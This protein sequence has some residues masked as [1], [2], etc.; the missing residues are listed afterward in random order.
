MRRIAPLIVAAAAFA[1]CCPATHLVYVYDLSIGIDAAYSNEGSG[2]VVFGY[3]RG[4]YSVVP[5]RTDLVTDANGSKDTDS[6]ELMSLAAVSR[7]DS[8]GVTQFRFDHLISTGP[9][10]ESLVQSKDGLEKV[11]DAI[12]G[13][14][15]GSNP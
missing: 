6:G 15:E 7:V 8:L 10:A 9:A 12:Y 14:K 4:T 5:Q 1:G 13:P 3:D 11:R 2:R